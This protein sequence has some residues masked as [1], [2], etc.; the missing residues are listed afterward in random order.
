M[1]KIETKNYE[2]KKTILNEILYYLYLF[3]K[4][5]INQYFFYK[6]LCWIVPHKVYSFLLIHRPLYLYLRKNGYINFQSR[7]QDKNK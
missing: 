4:L 2:K 1:I 3:F 7:N 6:V 5:Q